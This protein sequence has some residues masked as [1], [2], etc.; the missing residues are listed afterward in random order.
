MTAITMVT[1]MKGTAI[2]M[3]AGISALLGKRR[4]G[5]VRGAHG[6]PTF[7]SQYPRSTAKSGC[8]A[9]KSS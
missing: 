2:L 4:K 8:V 5:V 3:A 7:A 9:A 6:W 1:T